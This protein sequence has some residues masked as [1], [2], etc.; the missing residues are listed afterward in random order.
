MYIY[1]YMSTYIYMDA[2]GRT[3]V[4]AHEKAPTPRG[5]PYIPRHKA[6][7]GS[8]GGGVLMSEVPL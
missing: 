2:Q 5:S 3:S 6:T 1:V 4:L 7:V 8:Y